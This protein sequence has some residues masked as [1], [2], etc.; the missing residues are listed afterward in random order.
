MSPLLRTYISRKDAKLAKSDP[1]ILSENSVEAPCSQYVTDTLRD[2]PTLSLHT[3]NNP[4]CPH[5]VSL[6]NSQLEGTLD[7]LALFRSFLVELSQLQMDLTLT[8][9]C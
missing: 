8:E 6:K 4:S 9:E 1:G 3:P 7:L 2:P 5:C